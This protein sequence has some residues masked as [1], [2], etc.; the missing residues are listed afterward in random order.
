VGSWQGKILYARLRIDREKLVVVLTVRHDQAGCRTALLP[1]REI[2]A[3]LPRH[4]LLGESTR[5]PRELLETLTA[6][7]EKLTV[8]R[9]VH[10]RENRS[11]RIAC[12]PSWRSVRFTGEEGTV[13][14]LHD[15]TEGHGDIQGAFDSRHRD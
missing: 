10:V 11:H 2:S 8:G 13:P 5:A 12:F 6:I 1:D 9:R 4:I 15:D 7:V 14:G 3:L